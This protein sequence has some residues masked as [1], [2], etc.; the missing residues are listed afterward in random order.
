METSRRQYNEAGTTVTFENVSNLPV[1]KKV[2]NIQIN[3]LQ[4]KRKKNT[5]VINKHKIQNR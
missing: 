3:I 1:L 5:K 4:N 2:E